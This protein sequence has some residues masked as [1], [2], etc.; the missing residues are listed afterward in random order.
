MS[1]ARLITAVLAGGAA[2]VAFSLPAHAETAIPAGHN[3]VVELECTD[4]GGAASYELGSHLGGQHVSPADIGNHR[5][6]FPASSVGVSHTGGAW[7]VD[8]DLDSSLPDLGFSYE[9]AAGAESVCADSVTITLDSGVTFGGSST[10]TLTQAADH[11][12]GE[13]RL[14]AA[15][16]TATS[17]AVSLD[18]ETGDGAFAET[19]SPLNIT[20]G[21]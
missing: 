7:V 9:V 21:S 13:W 3:D 14:P 1:S 17:Y 8:A 20:A 15:S 4:A 5:A 19:L 10:V 12:H 16:A 2:S 6:T 18:V 11:V